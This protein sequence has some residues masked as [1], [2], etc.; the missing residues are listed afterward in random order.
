MTELSAAISVTQA[1]SIAETATLHSATIRTSQLKSTVLLGRV[2][3]GLKGSVFI[4]THPP[5][6]LLEGEFGDSVVRKPPFES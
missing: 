3:G 2:R 4:E 5:F 1:A 6:P